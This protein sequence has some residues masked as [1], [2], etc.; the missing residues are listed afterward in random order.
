[1]NKNSNNGANSKFITAKVRSK[2][3]KPNSNTTCSFKERKK[4]PISGALMITNILNFRIKKDLNYGSLLI[5][6]DIIFCRGTAHFKR[7]VEGRVSSI[8]KIPRWLAA[9]SKIIESDTTDYI[10]LSINKRATSML[11]KKLSSYL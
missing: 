11:N 4:L 10:T 5:G 6:M 8:N 7:E 1:M 2:Y 9:V 3:R